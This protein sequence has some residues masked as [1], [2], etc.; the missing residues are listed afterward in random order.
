MI[1]WLT[2][3]PEYFPPLE[4]ALD[5]PNGLLAAGGDLSPQ[6]LLSAYRCGIF[7]W[8]NP[9]EPILWWSPNPRMVLFPGELKISRSLRKTIARDTYETRYDTAFRT[10]MQECA[11]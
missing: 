10:V 1:H 8:F 2:P 4:M 9:E 11:A 7:P 3:N 6:R 5:E